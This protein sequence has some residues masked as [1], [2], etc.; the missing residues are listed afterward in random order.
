MRFGIK[1]AESADTIM[2]QAAE[3]PP[4]RSNA[5]KNKV[6]KYR[7][8]QEESEMTETNTSGIITAAAD[9]IA[10][11][12]NALP[13]RVCNQH[14]FSDYADYLHENLPA[15]AEL[16]LQRE[17]PLNP[18]P[19][20]SVAIACSGASRAAVRST[21]EAL[22]KQTYANFEVC[23]VSEL[24]QAGLTDYEGIPKFRLVLFNGTAHEQLKAAEKMLNG[25]YFLQLLPGDLPAPDALHMLVLQTHSNPE[26]EVVFADE[27]SVIDGIRQNPIFKP[28]YGRD[29]LRSFNSIGRPM[30][31]SKRVHTA[32]GGFRG[33]TPAELWA[34]CIDCASAAKQVIHIARIGLTV[35]RDCDGSEIPCTDI[36]K[37]EFNS[38]YPGDGSGKK[39]RTNGYC[40]EGSVLGTLRMRYPRKREPSVGIVIAGADGVENLQR[41]IDSAE[42][43]STVDCRRIIIADDGSGDERMRRYLQALK[44]NRAAEIV[45]VNAEQP[46]P[47]TLNACACKA[48]ADLLLF[49]NG[50]IEILS[51]AFL[52]EFT[53][54]ALRHGAGAIGGKIVNESGNIL[55]AGTVIGLNGWAQSPYSGEKD[56]FEDFLKCSFLHVQRNVTAVSGAFMAVSGENFFSFGM[57]DETLAGVGWDTEFCVRLM[58]KGL[59]NCFT[60]FAKA[61]LSGKLPNDYAN[62]GKANLLRCYDVYRETLLCGDR[63]FNP[64]F[65]YANPVP[66][67]AAVPYPPIKLN[68]LYSG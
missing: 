59:A 13:K 45:H 29:T 5:V 65:D 25:A 57:F 26:A 55:S 17:K 60:P 38:L 54:L 28:D 21:L 15:Q 19:L 42:M 11:A 16:D 8:M 44:K 64:N 6:Q 66:T 62:A 33:S 18:A 37:R 46:L 53:E 63:Y 50:N 4:N 2:Q 10:G 12:F 56:D 58:R 40:F 27:D 20:V 41:C 30:L 1:I 51:P 68:P 61:R 49:L 47:E 9:I 23:V 43:Q 48:A 31:V 7:M 35:I 36:L 3:Q 67:L 24:A 14:K 22:G 32:V 52:R 39:N 34:Y